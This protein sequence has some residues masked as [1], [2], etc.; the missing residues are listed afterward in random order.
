MRWHCAS[1]RVE[2]IR[3]YAVFS[4]QLLDVVCRLLILHFVA[5]PAANQLGCKLRSKKRARA[6]FFSLFA[7][8]FD[9][10]KNAAK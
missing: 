5:R 2:L 8:E 4:H 7:D 9:D 6:M 1:D 3:C 10:T